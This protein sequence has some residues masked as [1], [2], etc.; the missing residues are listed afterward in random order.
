MKLQVVTPHGPKV[1]IAVSQVTVPASEGEMG[2]LPGH[3]PF[4]SGLATGVLRYTSEDGG[5]LLA[6]SGGYIEVAD[7]TVIVVS[8]TAEAPTEI[9]EVRAE[10]SRDQAKS[11]LG[12]AE[13]GSEDWHNAAAKL[14][15]A[16]N[17][18]KVAKLS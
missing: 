16:E 3:L 1:D 11:I 12:D 13:G 18:L 7:D 4:M 15:R 6:V 2:I 17:R 9:D 5:E 14:A 10:T 8:E